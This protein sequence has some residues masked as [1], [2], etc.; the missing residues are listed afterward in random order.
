MKQVVVLFLIL[1]LVPVRAQKT[2]AVPKEAVLVI[3]SH[4]IY[5]EK[6]LQQMEK[7]ATLLESNNFKVHRFYD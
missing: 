1:G 4:S 3:G 6:S 5:N 7:I 2:A